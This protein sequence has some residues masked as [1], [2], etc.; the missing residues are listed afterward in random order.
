MR[1][2]LDTGLKGVCQQLDNSRGCCTTECATALKHPHA[3]HYKYAQQS[4]AVLHHKR[5]QTALLARPCCS[6]LAYASASSSA[7]C[8]AQLQSA[9]N[10]NTSIS[11]ASAG[12]CYTDQHC[13]DNGICVNNICICQDDESSCQPECLPAT[14]QED[15][16]IFA[17]CSCC[18]SGMFD[19][20]GSCCQWT[21][22]RRPT[23]DA[24]GQCCGA[25]YLDACGRCAGDSSWG[26]AVD[27]NGVC[28][29]VRI[30]AEQPLHGLQSLHRYAT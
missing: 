25:G 16:A 2:C 14:A 18:L 27:R 6:D 13:P 26:F 5:H 24:Q 3:A 22:K 7:G 23:L 29:E 11:A 8:D 30:A 10:A 28:C 19:T 4:C 15:T 12:S 17:S 21:G 9:S 20:N 1:S